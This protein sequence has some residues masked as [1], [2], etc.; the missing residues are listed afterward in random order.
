MKQN[1]WSKLSQLF[2]KDGE[3]QSV[4]FSFRPSISK[5]AIFIPIASGALEGV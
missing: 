1:A 3:C 4:I 5:K 2:N